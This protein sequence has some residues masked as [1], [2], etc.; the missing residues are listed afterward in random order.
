MLES[1]G[2]HENDWLRSLYEIRHKWSTT[3]NKDILDLGILSTQR[4]ESTNSVCHG[5][6]KPTSTLTDCFLGMKK[7]IARWR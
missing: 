7:I 2:L 4:S 3:M 5:I 6:S 1:G